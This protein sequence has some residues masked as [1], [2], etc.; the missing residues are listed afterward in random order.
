MQGVL[1]LDESFDSCITATLTLFLSST[2]PSSVRSSISVDLQKV[3]T[4][5]ARGPPYEGV[6]LGI[7]PVVVAVCGHDDDQFRRFELIRDRNPAY[8]NS[9]L[10]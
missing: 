2:T 4:S 5:E 9:R 1:D 10:S 6:G 3:L 7:C 8:L